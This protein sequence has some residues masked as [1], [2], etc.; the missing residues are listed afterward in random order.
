MRN[1]SLTTVLLVAA[2]VFFSLMVN[3]E[4]AS[5]P[6]DGDNSAFWC[7]ESGSKVDDVGAIYTKDG[8]DG[9]YKANWRDDS[10]S[11]KWSIVSSPTYSGSKAWKCKSTKDRSEVATLIKHKPLVNGARWFA[12]AIRIESLGSGAFFCQYHQSAEAG[13]P[14]IFMKYDGSKWILCKRTDNGVVGKN[15]YQEL[16]S[17]TM[18]TNTWYHFYM[19]LKAGLNG[20]AEIKLWQKK[21]GSWQEQSLNWGSYPNTVGFKYNKDGSLADWESFQYKCGI[22]TKT[23]TVYFD[24]ISYGKT[25][26]D[27]KGL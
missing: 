23:G 15:Y 26:S 27:L 6:R 4:G 16:A 5:V 18:N 14:P 25:K 1:K 21:S 24:N 9:K 22:Y 17:G 10:S 3:V 2:V 20:N 7:A 8:Y 13:N 11:P 12:F 19:K